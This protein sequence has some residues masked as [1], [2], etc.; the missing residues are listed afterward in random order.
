MTVDGT[1]FQIRQPSLRTQE[2]ENLSKEDK[3]KYRKSWYSHKFKGPGLRYEVGVCIFSGNICW[4]NGPFK[5]GLMNDIQIFRE[6]LRGCLSPGEQ[7]V[8]DKGYKGDP[9]YVRVPDRNN[10]TVEDKKYNSDARMRQEHVNRYFKTWK[11]LK[12]VYR[13]DRDSHC[14]VFWSVAVLTQ[15]S[16]DMGDKHTWQFQFWGET[17]DEARQYLLNTF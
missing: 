10:D 9:L 14:M 11:I 6:K 1:D 7:V 5:P 8:A 16:F 15:I 13:H 4:I 3:K 17:Y 12:E 2:I